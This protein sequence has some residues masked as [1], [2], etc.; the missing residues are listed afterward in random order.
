M[1][2][3]RERQPGTDADEEEELP[4]ID[5]VVNRVNGGERLPVDVGERALGLLPCQTCRRRQEA[6]PDTDFTGIVFCNPDNN[7]GYVTG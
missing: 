3:V 1:Q 5:A 7:P 4:Q 2:L 6:G